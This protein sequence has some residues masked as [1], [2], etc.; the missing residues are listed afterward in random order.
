MQIS[1][2]EYLS[3][4]NRFGYWHSPKIHRA[5]QFAVISW[6]LVGKQYS[7]AEVKE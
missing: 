6:K 2:F 4:F 1:S 5:L 3:S 7:S